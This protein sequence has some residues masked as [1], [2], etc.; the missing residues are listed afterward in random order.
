[1][2]LLLKNKNVKMLLLL[3]MTVFAV[4]TVAV[5]ATWTFTSDVFIDGGLSLG[6][7]TNNPATG[8]IYIMNNQRRV[9]PMTG[10]FGMHNLTAY[11]SASGYKTSQF[12]AQDDG[13]ASMYAYRNNYT[14]QAKVQA[15]SAGHAL[16]ESAVTKSSVTAHSNGDVIIKLGN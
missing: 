2:K 1:M 10:A 15:T 11:T 13:T 16:M 4:S 14:D 3:A 6:F 8:T 9:E 7:N 12:V 5:A